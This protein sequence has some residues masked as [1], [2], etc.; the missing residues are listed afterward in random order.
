MQRTRRSA[1]WNILREI[2]PPPP[3]CVCVCVGGGLFFF[4]LFCL[5]FCF[6]HTVALFNVEHATTF[7][8]TLKQ[9][10]ELSRGFEHTDIIYT[11]E[12]I[13]A[14]RHV[15]VGISLS[16]DIGLNPFPACVIQDSR[17]L[18]ASQ[19]QYSYQSETQFVKYFSKMWFA[20]KSYLL[21]NRPINVYK[22]YVIRTLNT[23]ASLGREPD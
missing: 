21:L 6:V 2:P 10:E 13:S 3:L 18:A 5:V 23:N 9:I 11:I 15:I 8:P 22:E 7:N 19:P 20:F 16:L 4:L 14:D 1:F 12:R 17:H